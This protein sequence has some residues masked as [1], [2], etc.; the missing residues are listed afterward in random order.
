MVLTLQAALGVRKIGAV[1]L[2]PAGITVSLVRELGPVLGALMVAGRVGSGISSQIGSM[3]V[4]YQLDAMRV[5]GSD[6][7]RKLIIPR[8]LALIVIMPVLTVILIFFGLVSANIMAEVSLNINTVF[9]WNSAIKS[10]KFFDIFSTMIKATVFGGI[11][12]LMGS[13]YGLSTEGGTEG[14]GKSATKSVVIISVSILFA[15]FILTK[16]FYEIIK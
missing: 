2:V 13:Y 1:S 15:D 16:I 7:I 12:G 11:I 6:P 8:F 5:L 9:F 4:T 10:L 14:V 3:K